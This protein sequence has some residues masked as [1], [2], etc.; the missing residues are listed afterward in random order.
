M[1]CGRL[2]E[3][4]SSMVSDCF[5]NCCNEL[6]TWIFA[7]VFAGGWSSMVIYFLYSVCLGIDKTLHVAPTNC[8]ILDTQMTSD[9]WAIHVNYTVPDR[10]TPYISLLDGTNSND[11]FKVN[12]TLTC[13]YSTHYAQYVVQSPQ[14]VNGGTI[15]GLLILCAMSIPVAVAAGFVLLAILT[16]LSFLLMFIYRQ[17]KAVVI[18]MKEK[19]A[20]ITAKKSSI[21]NESDNSIQK[22]TTWKTIVSYLVAPVNYCKKVIGGTLARA[23]AKPKEV[24]DLEDQV[25]RNSEI[26]SRDSYRSIKGLLS[27]S[28]H[29]YKHE[30]QCSIGSS[31]L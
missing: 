19:L 11:I 6:C 5:F 12:Q 3:D 15:F 25:T 18:K 13:Y 30:D 9:G 1:G 4:I 27:S 17:C 21:E 23:K 10:S 8:T 31:T 28:K 22:T 26:S 7:I 2:I 20:S 14:S 29:D 16:Q 24:Y